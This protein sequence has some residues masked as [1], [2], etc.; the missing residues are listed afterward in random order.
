LIE[1]GTAVLQAAAAALLR[2]KSYSLTLILIL[3]LTLGT[4]LTVLQLN[5]QILAAPLP[6]PQAERLYVVRG[7]T[8]QADKQEY[9]NLLTLAGA[10]KL[11]QQAANWS[12]P[13]T[14]PQVPQQRAQQ[15]PA[16]QPAIEQQA[17]VAFQQDVIRNRDDSPELHVGYVSP[18][19][20][21]LLQVPM[22]AGR[23][24]MP[25]DG[26][27]Q[28]HAV[29]VISD[30][31]WRLLF[32][33][34]PAALGQQLQLG[35]VS[36]R[37]IGVT[38]ATFIEPA[39]LG[40]GQHTDLWLPWD[41][42]PTY[43]AF[44]HWWGALA[45]DHH[46]I[47]KLAPQ[48]DAAQLAQQLSVPLNQAYR[49]AVDASPYAEHFVQ[50]RIGISL[51]PLRQV[52]QADSQ[53]HSLLALLGAL[54]LLLI[55]LVSLAQLFLARQHSRQQQHAIRFALGASPQ[56]VA[57]QTFA[58]LL[59]I[60]LTSAVLALW[61]SAGLIPWIRDWGQGYL[62]RMRELRLELS[63][64][65]GL[66][67]LLLP[68]AYGASR[69]KQAKADMSALQQQ[70]QRSG[71]GSHTQHTRTGR[72]LLAAQA[73]VATVLLFCCLQ[74]ATHSSHLL[75][76]AP[77]FSPQRVQQL[78]LNRQSADATARAPLA[79][80]LAI[81][82]AL[83]QQTGIELTALT[84]SIMLDFTDQSVQDSLSWPDQAVQP[85]RLE[86][87]YSDGQVIPLLQIPLLSGRTFNAQELQQQATVVLINA[88]AAKQLWQRQPKKNA[89]RSSA[90]AA[91]A[92]VGQR[93]LL[94]GDTAVTV[95]GVV[96]DL[97]L[98]AKAEPPRLWLANFYH[99]LPDVLLKY[100]SG[101]RYLTVPQLNQL[102]AQ[103]APDYRVQSAEL[104]E[105]KM[106]RSQFLLRLSLVFSLLLSLTALLLAFIGY[107]GVLTDQL[108]L[109]RYEIAIHVALGARPAQL[110]R[111]LLRDYLM[112]V[113]WG[114]SFASLCWAVLWYWP[115]LS[116]LLP[117]WL[118]V[119]NWPLLLGSCCGLLLL[120][121]STVWYCSRSLLSSQVATLLQPK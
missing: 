18:E 2:A 92:M 59:I 111:Q 49:T 39:L 70:L 91:S 11:Y 6:Y 53:S 58:E 90:D 3:A 83:Q 106:Q 47:F 67:A 82:S 88:S 15:L 9:N 63:L 117:G 121:A 20:F 42:N 44:R 21:S 23:A 79:D 78:T 4:L 64:W 46:L 1:V 107:Y 76:Q 72:R 118:S 34:D 95:V 36:F 27:D 112:P 5:Y 103:V 110:R 94:N 29:V 35:T 93:L 7:Q 12:L 87:N 10:V 101:S 84:S 80:L 54:L 89:A 51:H 98:N 120:T 26:L 108:R 31:L 24:L 50:S 74:L 38:A 28:Q 55:A 73:L 61:L 37:I 104:L 60:C 30:R 45:P 41:Y 32:Q 16:Q 25:T 40:P 56:Q 62:P 8:Y 114:A 68:L 48:T 85:L 113:A 102:L 52:I 75:G 115:L 81:R 77:G 22:A 66:L 69:V 119:I 33:R 57:Q 19:Y 116:T 13:T 96:A 43:Q 100:Q 17:L 71:K 65:F 97:Q 14:L 105:Q 99:F 86:S 109:R